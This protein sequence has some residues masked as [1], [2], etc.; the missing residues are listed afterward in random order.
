MALPV[1]LTEAKIASKS[2]GCS[3]LKSNT[4]AEIERFLSN[5]SIAQ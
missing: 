1:F 3:V 5:V 4:S 2:N